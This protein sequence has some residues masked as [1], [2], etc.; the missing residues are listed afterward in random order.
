MAGGVVLKNEF[1]AGLLNQLI[2][3]GHILFSSGV[4]FIEAWTRT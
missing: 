4:H 1:V 3:R 2:Y